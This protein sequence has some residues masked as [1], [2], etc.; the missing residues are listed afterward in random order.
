MSNARQPAKFATRS[1]AQPFFFCLAGFLVFILVTGSNVFAQGQPQA[2]DAAEHIADASERIEAELAID[3]S[4]LVQELT[5][6]PSFEVRERA[7]MDLWADYAN[8]REAVERLATSADPDVARRARWILERWEIGLLPELP[9]DVRQKLANSA[10]APTIAFQTLLD[11]QRIREAVEVARHAMEHTASQPLRAEIAGIVAQ[12]FTQLVYMSLESEQVDRLINLLDVSAE[13]TSLAVARS[14]LLQRLGRPLDDANILPICANDWPIARKREVEITCW[15]VLGEFDKAVLLAERLPEPDLLFRVLLAAGRWDDLAEL[16]GECVETSLPADATMN[17]YAMWIVAAR[18]AGREHD[19]ASVAA[20]LSDGNGGSSVRWK[21]LAAAGQLNAAIE[22]AKTLD[23]FAA[24]DLLRTQMRYNE[25]FALLQ[26]DPANPRPDIERMFKA[27]AEHIAAENKPGQPSTTDEEALQR[28]TTS[29]EV[30]KSVGIDDLVK[31]TL[32]RISEM[33]DSEQQSLRGRLQAIITAKQLGMT[34]LLPQIMAP[35]GPPGA[36]ATNRLAGA[37]A[38]Y[39]AKRSRNLYSRLAF[40]IGQ[41]KPELD[42]LERWQAMFN[43][44]EGILPENWDRQLDLDQLYSS[45]SPQNEDAEQLLSRLTASYAVAD[46]FSDLGR[47]D[48]AAECYAAAIGPL[49]SSTAVME[50]AKH[51][52]A[53]GQPEAALRLLDSV[54]EQL[55]F[56]AQISKYRPQDPSDSLIPTAS[57]VLLAKSI[58]LRRLGRTEEAEPIEQALFLVPFQPA[59]NAGEEYLETLVEFSELGRIETDVPYDLRFRVL[60]AE[61]PW[62]LYSR[63]FQFAHALAE[64][65]PLL[66]SRW[67]Q[68]GFANCVSR[69]E[70]NPRSYTAIP[71]V[72]FATKALAAAQQGDEQATLQ[73]LTDARLQFPVDITMAEETLLKIR[74]IGMRDVADRVTDSIFESGSQYVQQ[75][76]NDANTLNNL[77]WVSSINGRNYEKALELAQRAVFL[78]PDSVSYRDTLAEV[79]FRLGRIDEAIALQRQCLLDS[80]DHWHL[81]EQIA[82]FQAASRANVETQTRAETLDH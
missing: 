25:A 60:D 72:F 33:Q 5:S 28:L 7:M 65:S 45:M 24:I 17:Q 73:A 48:I 57:S 11:S 26:L 82:R 6:S 27:A 16:S 14:I 64:S 47:G 51:N 68:I 40:A 15:C 53:V 32:L 74:K 1:W 63:S 22:T 35:L 42:A 50:F 12:R 76:A 75:F 66:S 9:W 20:T 58:A 67:F 19:V 70:L 21:A 54:A 41:V 23:P 38:Q 69:L 71:A 81:H 43:L 34:E 13:T 2:A 18:F 4:Q 3:S 78:E 29:L 10:H 52:L 46:F 36:E 80:P 49:Y 44:L 61:N 77:A 62:N 39:F 30:M 37:L 56:S 31:P 8:S 59:E 79:L 55:N